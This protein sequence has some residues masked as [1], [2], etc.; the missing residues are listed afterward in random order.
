VAV[1]QKE[2]GHVPCDKIPDL[3]CAAQALWAVLFAAILTGLAMPRP[4]VPSYAG[5]PDELAAW[6]VFAPEHPACTGQI[7]RLRTGTNECE[8]DGEI[9]ISTRTKL[10]DTPPLSHSEMEVPP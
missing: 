3:V 4:F 2:E 6:L 8:A 1:L 7:P 5:S 9:L 10:S